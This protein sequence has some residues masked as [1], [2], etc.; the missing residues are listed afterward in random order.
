MARLGLGYI[1]REIRIAGIDDGCLNNTEKLRRRFLVGVIYRGG[2]WIDG[3]FKLK[4][5]GECLDLTNRLA[6]TIKNSSHY[7]QI[8]LIMLN[9]L[10]F[11]GLNSLNP[12]KLNKKLKK[13]VMIVASK[14]LKI[15]SIKNLDP[16]DL[17]K[18][19]KPLKIE[20]LNRLN[21]YVYLY[22]LSLKE[23]EKVLEV[24]VYDGLPEP[25][26]VARLIA[27]SLNSSLTQNI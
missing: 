15:E 1:K 27:K 13:P 26:K 17:D 5:R 9:K 23:A 3:V 19:K 7:G 16:S 6:K 14:P 4:V 20:A 2:S 8:R 24:T 22:G 18:L 10:L 12:S 21:F 11:W 25:L